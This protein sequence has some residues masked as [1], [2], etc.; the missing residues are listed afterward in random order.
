MNVEGL[1]KKNN[2]PVFSVF[3]PMGFAILFTQV[4][5]TVMKPQFFRNI[6]EELFSATFEE[7]SLKRIL[8]GES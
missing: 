2:F 7:Q 6:D 5:K 4:G 8:K 1:M 3:T